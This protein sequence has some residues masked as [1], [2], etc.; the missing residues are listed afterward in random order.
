MS[1]APPGNRY[2]VQAHTENTRVLNFLTCPKLRFWGI[3]VSPK[4]TSLVNTSLHCWLKLTN[5][6][7]QNPHQ[8]E[9]GWKAMQ[10]QEGCAMDAHFRGGDGREWPSG[11]NQGPKEQSWREGC[12]PRKLLHTLGSFAVSAYQDLMTVANQWL[13]WV[14]IFSFF[15]TRVP[16]MLYCSCVLSYIGCDEA[17]NLCMPLEGTEPWRTTSRFDTAGCP[18][19]DPRLGA[20]CRRWVELWSHLPLGEDIWSS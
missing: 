9:V 18:Y 15:W 6:K 4:T 7:P 10:P 20:G 3:Y 14:S 16:T 17:A 8:Q 1:C 11:D 12:R 2:S 13:Q 5:L 19:P